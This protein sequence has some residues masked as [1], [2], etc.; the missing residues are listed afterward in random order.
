MQHYFIQPLEKKGGGGT[1]LSPAMF[2]H[3]NGVASNQIH[4]TLIP[5]SPVKIFQL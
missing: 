3:F 1:F 5:L 4:V 2:Y